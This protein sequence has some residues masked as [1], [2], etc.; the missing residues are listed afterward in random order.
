VSAW[1]NVSSATCGEA[2]HFRRYLLLHKRQCHKGQRDRPYSHKCMTCGKSFERLS[3]LLAHQPLY[4]GDKPFTCN[5]CGS[6]Y[7]YQSGLSAHRKSIHLDS[8]KELVNKDVDI[9]M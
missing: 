4:S 9:R 1:K 6:T 8:I 5:K 2:Y 3:A 7:R